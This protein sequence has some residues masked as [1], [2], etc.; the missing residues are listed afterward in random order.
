MAKLSSVAREAKA[1]A[2][3]G[4]RVA[5]TSYDRASSMLLAMLV[6]IGVVVSLL[7]MIWLSNR[8]HYS[9]PSVP[10]EMAEYREDGEG[11]GDGRPAGGTQLETPSDEPFVATAEKPTDV[12]RTWPRW[13]RPCPRARPSWTTPT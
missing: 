13:T 4:R 7:F 3:E 6:S 1:M 5:V 10:V 2:L 12:S 9:Q 11:G 8:I